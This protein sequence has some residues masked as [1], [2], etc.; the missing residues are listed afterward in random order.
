MWDGDTVAQLANTSPATSATHAATSL[1]SERIISVDVLR[2]LV[3]VI[4]ALDHTRDFFT[5][6]RFEPE[7]IGHTY[8]ALFYT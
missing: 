8:P 3:V 7:Q 2:G 6:I 5:K 4:M 1:R